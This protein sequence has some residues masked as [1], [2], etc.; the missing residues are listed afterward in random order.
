[1]QDARLVAATSIALIVT[2]AAI[3]AMRPLASRLGLVDRPDARKRHHGRI[4]LIGGLCF[5]LGT[6]A[7][8]AY[9][10]YLD[11]FGASL[12]GVGALVLLAGVTDDVVQVSVR[13]RLIIQACAVG[14]MIAITGIHVDGAGHLWGAHELRLYGFGIPFTVVAV[15]G[16]INA[17]NMMDGI[18]GL[19][20]S[21][22]MVSIGAIMLFAGLSPATGVMVVLQILFAAMIPY[23]FVNLGGLGG[24]KIFMGDAGS[25]LLGFLL[26]WSLIYLSH[27]DV[28]R[29]APVDVL[30]CIALPVMDTLAVMQQR[31][32]QG[33]SPFKPDR[34]HLHHLLLQA[35]MSP[36]RALVAMVAIG[37]LL[38]AI[39]ILLRNVAEPLSL[40]V[41]AIALA[42]Y[43]SRRQWFAVRMQAAMRDESASMPTRDA[44]QQAMEV[45]LQPAGPAV[46][47][48]QPATINDPMAD[49]VIEL[50]GHRHV[51]SPATQVRALCVLD[52][53]PDAIT[54]APVAQALARDERFD[55]RVCVASPADGAMDRMLQQYGLRPDIQLGVRTRP[56]D[57]GNEASV[58]LRGIHR[59][60]GELRPDIVLVQGQ[61]PVA[62]ATAL[63][64]SY[65][66]IP[67]ACIDSESPSAWAV[68]HG[69]DEINHLITSQLAALHFA[70]TE[71]VE[72]DLIAAG[73]RP[74]RIT[75]AGDEADACLRIADALARLPERA[76]PLA[77]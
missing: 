4:P 66:R 21:M 19:A 44:P 76:S 25:T 27:R 17:F 35:G 11:R 1:M 65:Q 32:R 3:F 53:S 29:M 51:V 62:M 64:A 43:V 13:A 14:L 9:F 16:L 50:E 31:A 41:F 45:A 61:A 54:V 46:A 72:R 15:I 52:R 42:A 2:F 55:A 77:A 70:A 73:V 40:A 28:G 5:F 23:L 37:S 38:G 60:L 12:L 26:A 22:A 74:D 67:V 36:R 33:R 59:V 24:R 56:G 49:T 7:G 71:S 63:A 58:A 69:P 30:W 34:Q 39:G 57:P 47:D 75:I 68:P 10:G 18:D 8:L 6:L 48:R 20:G